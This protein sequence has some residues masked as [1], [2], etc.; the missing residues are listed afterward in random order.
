MTELGEIIAMKK[1]NKIYLLSC[2]KKSTKKIIQKYFS[3]TDC[4]TAKVKLVKQIYKFIEQNT[5]KFNSEQIEQLE[6]AVTVINA[7]IRRK[8]H[9]KYHD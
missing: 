8:H 1:I 9:A 2:S 4:N 7:I 6:D 3:T 5:E